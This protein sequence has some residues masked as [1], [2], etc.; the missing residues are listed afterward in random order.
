MDT[1]RFELTRAEFERRRLLRRATYVWSGT[2]PGIGEV[3]LTCPRESWHSGE[4]QTARV[5]G[6]GVPTLAFRGVRFRGLP[7]MAHMQL[8]AGVNN[9][10]PRRR[11]LAVRR[12]E[13]ALR[14]E[15]RGRSYRY[16]VLDDKR[17]HELTRKGVVV[18]MTRSEWRRPRTISGVAEGDADGLDVGLA[19]L[20][21]SVYT[22]NLS[23]GGAVYSWPGRFLSRL[24]PTDLADLLDL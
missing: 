5:A 22:R 16:R 4:K 24:D 2:L 15:V 18:T 8:S 21:E 3:R 12:S 13:R 10:R 20:L 7:R 9:C 14:I 6:E 17:R 23:F 19:I 1:M 11:H